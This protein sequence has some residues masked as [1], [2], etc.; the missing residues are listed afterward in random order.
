[1]TKAKP[2]PA[3]AAPAAPAP[4]STADAL[5]SYGYVY[6][7]ANSIP[8]L[9][10]YLDQAIQGGWSQDK[11]VASVESSQWW[12]QHADTVRNLAIQEAAEPG[13]YKQT[14]DNAKQR[15][16]LKAQQLGRGLDDSA[17]SSLAIQTLT[18]NA[19][20]DDNVLSQA[21]TGSSSITKGEAGSYAGQAANLQQHMTQ[22]AQ[23]YGIPY[24]GDWMDGWISKVE[25][26]A[27]S[28]DGFTSLVQAR[29][30]ASY[31]NLANQID[32]GMTVKDVADPYISTY[33][34]TLEVPTTQVTLDDP[35]IK[36]A[37]SSVDPKTGQASTVPLWQF[38]RQL[39][40]DPRYDK[41][42]QARTDVY[43]TL[44]KVG[45]AFGFFTGSGA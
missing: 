28:L 44:G 24:T 16:S 35:A 45:A 30:K 31:P 36:R 40:D 23:S 5:A 15:I 26:G 12:M 9:K 22:V 7:I 27:D 42:Q 37:L 38:Q 39:K 34:Q 8:E 2:A 13:T 10:N 6:Q 25:A 19:S 21:V 33:A 14:I 29:A 41:T 3:P 32:A 11:L 20:W 18:T 43:S 17:L 1:M 4:V